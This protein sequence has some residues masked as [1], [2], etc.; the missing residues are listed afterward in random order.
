MNVLT[1]PARLAS[2]TLA[3]A[4]LVAVPTAASAH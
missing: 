3:A 1:H 4:L 2:A